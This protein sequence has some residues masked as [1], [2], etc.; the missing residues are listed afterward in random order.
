M[1]VCSGCWIAIFCTVST[2]GAGGCWKFSTSPAWH[3]HL[4]GTATAESEDEM[5]KPNYEGLWW[6]LSEVRLPCDVD[7]AG[8]TCCRATEDAVCAGRPI[9]LVRSV[10]SSLF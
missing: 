4:G 7:D 10:C 8:A 9:Q 1:L 5:S 6:F 2:T 3:C